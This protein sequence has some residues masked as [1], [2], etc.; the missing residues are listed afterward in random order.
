MRAEIVGL[1]LCSVLLAEPA[2]AYDPNDQ[3][4]CNGVDWNDK[5][6]DWGDR[7]VLTVSKMTVPRVNFI[8]S[9]YDDDAKAEG[10]PAATKACRMKSYLVT[11]DLVLVG[12]TEQAFTCVDYQSPLAKKRIGVRGWLPSTALTPVSPMPSPKASDWVGSWYQPGGSIE[13]KQGSGGKLDVEAGMTV[14]TVRDFHIG[15]F[16]AKVTPPENDTIALTDEDEDGYGDGC[17][18]RLQRIGPWLLAEDNGGCGG[19]GV[20]FTGLYRPRK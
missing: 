17:Q 11:G 3:N 13:I 20:T 14:P 18:V 1:L 6:A 2:S 9:P 7:R 10:C 8:K 16:K 19:V 4:N 5:G 12:K 15:A